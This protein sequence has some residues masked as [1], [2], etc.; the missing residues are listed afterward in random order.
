MS[1]QKLLIGIVL[2]VVVVLG[3]YLYL[4]SSKTDEPVQS[5]TLA[6]SNTGSNPVALGDSRAADIAASTASQNEIAVLLKSVNQI[7]LDTT[8]LQNPSFLALQDTSLTLPDTTVSG[9]VNPFARSG[10]LDAATP[11][12]T[13]INNSATS[14]DNPIGTTN[15]ASITNS[16]TNT[17]STSSGKGTTPGKSQ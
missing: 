8:I 11:I 15:T 16:T 4:S 6:S 17:S 14:S 3:G 2:L 5:S 10:A 13:S 7:K 9:R 1:K 12:T